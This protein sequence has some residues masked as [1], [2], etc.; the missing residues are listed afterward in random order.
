M[1]LSLNSYLPYSQVCCL[2]YS[3]RSDNMRNFESDV[4]LIKYEVLKEVI[5]LTLEG[6][7]EQTYKSIPKKIIPGPKPRTR[8]CIYKEREIISQRVKLAMGGN[9]RNKNIIE[10]INVA[11]DE[12]PIHRFTITEACR[13]CL[14]HK[15]SEACPK[16]AIYTINQRAYID[17]NKCIECGRCKSVCPYNAISDVMR[18]C[19]RA[20]AAKA[21]SFDENKKAVID[22]DKCIQCGSCVYQCP[23]GAI[24]DK[25]F[26][27][28]VVNLLKKSQSDISHKVYAVIAPAISSQFT[29]AKIEQVVT[30][31]KRL[32]F[33]D[34]IE[35]A[36]G[37]DMVAMHEVKDFTAE[38]E[39]VKTMTSSCCPA[40][41]SY[42]KKS[43]PELEKHISNSVSPM[44][45]ISKLIKRMDKTAKVVFIG[46]CTAKKAEIL[47]P[48]LKGIT[49]YVITFEELQ[50]M[51]DAYEINIAECDSMPLN[52]ASFYGRIFARTGGLTEAI[53]HLLETEGICTEFKPVSCDGLS[54]CEKSLTL[55]KHNRLSNNFIEGMACIGGCIGGAA[56]LCH[57]PKDKKEVD[58]YGALA[59][60]KRVD[61]SLRVVKLE[62]I[63]LRRNDIA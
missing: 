36:L 14:A 43:F 12:C 45:A 3:E 59:L 1:L 55:L 19:R 5:K 39:E 40:F 32:G 35:A 29:Y 27:V 13:G 28:D 37:A 2:N 56:S 62:E 58:K 52:N 6:T 41:V 46:P 42:I 23:F 50:A 30:G 22:N 9:K 25:S 60:E 21:L 48:E 47:E 61:D 24:V 4:Q 17:T 54:E 51:F 49:D 44:I 15:C 11:C 53:G 63:D 26:V 31:I 7:L 38:I 57:G 10:V 18:P 33:H 20:C 8:C 16:N 34:V